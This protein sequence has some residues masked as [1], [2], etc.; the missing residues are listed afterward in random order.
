MRKKSQAAFEEE[1]VDSANY[2]MPRNKNN[3]MAAMA[4]PL[5]ECNFDRKCSFKAIKTTIQLQQ[6]IYCLKFFSDYDINKDIR[7]GCT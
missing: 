7:H 2:M 3:R 4:Q 6:Y 5:E 1:E